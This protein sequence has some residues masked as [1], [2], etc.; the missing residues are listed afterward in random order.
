MHLHLS[1]KPMQ[2]RLFML[3]LL[4]TTLPLAGCVHRTTRQVPLPLTLSDT[5][6]KRNLVVGQVFFE[7]SKG[8]LVDGPNL[9][10]L[11]LVSRSVAISPYSLSQADIT[12]AEFLNA[13]GGSSANCEAARRT[14]GLDDWFRAEQDN[15]I[16]EDV[17]ILFEDVR[18]EVADRKSLRQIFKEE[19]RRSSDKVPWRRSLSGNS[20]RNIDARRAVAIVEAVYAGQAIIRFRVS[21]KANFPKTSAYFVGYPA[22]QIE[23]KIR[24]IIKMIAVCAPQAHARELPDPGI[25]VLVSFSAKIPEGVRMAAFDQHQITALTPVDTIIH[26]YEAGRLPAPTHEEPRINPP[27]SAHVWAETTDTALNFLQTATD[28]PKLHEKSVFFK[29]CREDSCYAVITKEHEFDSE[30]HAY[31]AKQ[32]HGCVVAGNPASRNPFSALWNSIFERDI[33]LREL[34]LFFGRPQTGDAEGKYQDYTS[35]LI[36]NLQPPETLPSQ[37]VGPTTDV[38]IYEYD[39]KGGVAIL[40]PDSRPLTNLGVSGHLRGWGLEK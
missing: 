30:G 17:S 22:I 23:D 26:L 34:V 8:E 24:S 33:K 25:E 3:L 38:W 10:N 36:R 15:M 18:N 9:Q 12:L 7:G 35:A 6:T 5:R 16:G 14:E 32:P 11:G 28:Q 2:T 21:D 1:S 27:T 19:L 4:A 13:M 29:Y 39:C 20:S 40:R 31:T 37:K